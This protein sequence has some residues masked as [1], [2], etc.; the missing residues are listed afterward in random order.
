ML[1]CA[2]LYPPPLPPY[3]YL[4][5]HPLLVKTT[6]QLGFTHLVLIKKNKTTDS[7]EGKTGILIHG[8]KA[9]IVIRVIRSSALPTYN[10]K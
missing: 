4:M 8:G 7:N 3:L 5:A 6:N 2:A 10:I 9:Q 1:P